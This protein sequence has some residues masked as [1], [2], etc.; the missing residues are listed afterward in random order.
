MNGPKRRYT[1]P[2]C[3]VKEYIRNILRK[4]LKYKITR[5]IVYKLKGYMFI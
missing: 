4:I 1:K 2:K 3:S 5:L